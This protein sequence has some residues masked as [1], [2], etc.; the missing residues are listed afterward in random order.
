MRNAINTVVGAVLVFTA[1]YVVLL[2]VNLTS[3][4]VPGP[5]VGL[6][7]LVGVLFAFPQT[8]RQVARAVTFPLKHMSLLFVPAV[9]GVSIYWSDIKANALA[10]AIAIIITTSFCLGL[11]AWLTQALLNTKSTHKTQLNNINKNEGGTND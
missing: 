4:P 10:I 7:L 2:I 5:L 8:E 11:T 9:L 1:Y 3:L 6:L